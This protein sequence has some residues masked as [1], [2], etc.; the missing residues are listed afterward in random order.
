MTSTSKAP[1]GAS[2]KRADGRKQL[3]VYLEPEV[4]KELKKT[5]VDMETTASALTEQALQAWLK[6]AKTAKP[7]QKS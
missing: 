1:T 2:R 6:K 7:G 3:L 5:A 4:I